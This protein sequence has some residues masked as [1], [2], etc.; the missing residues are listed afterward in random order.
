MS[1]PLLTIT[2]FLPLAG[3]LLLQFIPRSQA[4]VIR[5]IALLIA[6]A[7][8][9]L[10][11]PILTN[12]HLGQAGMQLV[13][14]VSWIP[15]L[16][17][18]YFVGLDGLSLPLYEMTLLLMVVSVLASWSIKDRVREHYSMLLLLAVGMLGTFAAL[19]FILFYIFWELVL[20]PMYF[21]IGIW[22]GE[23]RT[24][25]AVKFF[26]YTLAGSVLMLVGILAL[27]FTSGLNTFDMVKL[28]EAGYHHYLATFIFITFFFG[29]AIKVPMWPFHTWLPD[30]HVQA[31]TAGSVLLAGVLLKMGTYAFVRIIVQ[32][33]PG[34]FTKFAPY[35]ALLAI[36]SIVYGAY[37]AL[38]QKDLKKMVAYSSVSHMGYVMLGIAA[39]TPVALNG[40]ILQMIN[41]GLITG[42]LFLL[43]G[44]IYERTHT[45][46]ISK[47]GGISVKI[48]VLGGMFVFAALAS[49]GLPGLS[50]FVGELLILLGSYTAY[51]IYT[52]LAVFTLALT[53][54][55][56][57]RANQNAIFGIPKMAMDGFKDANAREFFSMIP[58]VIFI[59]L[60]GIYPKPFLNYIDPAVN[61]VLQIIRGS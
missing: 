15:S 48:P 27:Y 54:F 8:L 29:F 35:I 39:L 1:Y 3:A 4:N 59:V 56:L 33:L 40:A 30:A 19:D 42:M 13:E 9:A 25:A 2:I 53:A 44:Y 12:Y 57:I 61:T 7:D 24:Y 22:G 32:I 14:K 41:H 58:L 17:I 31:P 10:G 20:I 23:N 51:Q 43:V 52:I 47:L 50:G 6:L 18:S 38:A 34:E 28:M 37:T 49:L 55:Y 11:I 5:T 60:I 21:I 46:D 26:L 36:I 16:G 45:R